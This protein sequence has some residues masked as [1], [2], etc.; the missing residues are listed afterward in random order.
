MSPLRHIDCL[1]KYSETVIYHR[2]SVVIYGHT[3]TTF[4]SILRSVNSFNV[5]PMKTQLYSH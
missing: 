3:K 5:K 2:N 1:G 4:E